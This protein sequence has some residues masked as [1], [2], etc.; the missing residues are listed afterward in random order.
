ML[1]AVPQKIM[2]SETGTM[3]AVVVRIRRFC[4]YC[5]NIITR[6][7]ELRE[8]RP[9]PSSSFSTS[10]PTLL[11][12]FPRELTKAKTRGN[13]RE[14]SRTC[15]SSFLPFWVQGFE[16]RVHKRDSLHW[17]CHVRTSSGEFSD[18]ACIHHVDMARRHCSPTRNPDQR[19]PY[20]LKNQERSSKGTDS[21]VSCLPPFPPSQ[22]EGHVVGT[23]ASL[24]AE[25]VSVTSSTYGL[26]MISLDL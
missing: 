17:C 20:T 15:I 22:L 16:P 1:T 26:K 3:T 25:L 14:P 5:L 23:S 19:P 24:C 10:S 12:R 9:L 2:R 11:H 7:W 6:L 8:A 21:G 18:C 13:V 4:R